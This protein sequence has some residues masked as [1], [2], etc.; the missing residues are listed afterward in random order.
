MHT[1]GNF[2]AGSFSPAHGGRTINDYNPATEAILATI[3]RSQGED[4]E[5]A[6]NAAHS[7]QDEWSKLTLEQ[8]A[9]WLDKIADAL[10]HK[11]EQI[12]NT[13]S[14]DTGKP[15]A[16]ARRV[17]AARSVSNFRFF[18]E[19]GHYWVRISVR[20]SIERMIKGISPF[21]ISTE[22]RAH[23]RPLIRL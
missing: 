10:E 22:I 8:R 20:I 7:A 16:L 3:P 4:V 18:A 12:A 23:F 11:S 5:R 19:F 13:E 6:V 17:D 2:I 1:I 21:K 15:I 14:R 9:H